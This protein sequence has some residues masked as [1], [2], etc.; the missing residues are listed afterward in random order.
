MSDKRDVVLCL[1]RKLVEKSRELGFNLSKT[2]ENHLRQLLTH[3]SSI[4]SMIN[5]NLTRKSSGWWA[6]PDLNRRPLARKAN[7]LTKLD[8]RPSS[9]FRS[10]LKFKSFRL[11]L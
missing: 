3:F 4:S 10:E 9:D 8:D 5:S 11:K 1:D 6:G 7:V 2:V